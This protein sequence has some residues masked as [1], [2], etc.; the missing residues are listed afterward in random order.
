MMQPRPQMGDLCYCLALV[1]VSD[2]VTFLAAFARLSLKRH[3]L[4]WS[5]RILILTHLPVNKLENLHG[6][7]S[8]RNAMLLH[9]RGDVKGIR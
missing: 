5:T 3:A 4:R 1:M 9:V 6:L 2:D 8:E 7:L